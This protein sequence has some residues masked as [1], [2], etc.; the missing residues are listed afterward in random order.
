SRSTKRSQA[1]LDLLD[2]CLRLSLLCQRPATQDR[3]PHPPGRKALVRGEA[4]GGFGALLGGIP[5]A[6]EV[7]DDGSTAQGMPEAIGVRQLLRQ[8]HRLLALRQ[9]LGRRAQTPQCLGGKAMANHASVFPIE[10]RRGAMV[11]G[12]V[13]GYALCKVRVCRGDRSQI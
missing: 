1:L 11:L 5:L 2:P 12:V 7:M 9:P 3:T 13:E 10:E 6:T 4:H 8:R